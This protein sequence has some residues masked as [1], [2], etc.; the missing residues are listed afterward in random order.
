MKRKS[1]YKIFNIIFIFLLCTGVLG[2]FREQRNTELIA[3]MEN[4]KI[5]DF[6]VVNFSSRD[7]FQQFEQ[8]FSDRI[9]GR[10]DLIRFWSSLN[11]KVFNVLISHDII[12]GKNGFFF[13]P[14][15][16]EHEIVDKGEKFTQLEKINSLCKENNARFIFFIAPHSEWIL[17][18]HLPDKY[19]PVNMEEV[20]GE[21]RQAL[22]ESNI[23]Y[24]LIGSKIQKLDLATRNSMYYRG[25]Y[26]WN[27]KGAHFAS[28]EL[29]N[30]LQLSDKMNLPV[31]YK[32]GNSTADIYTK[33]IGWEPIRSEYEIPWSDKFTE[34]IREECYINGQ[35][36]R[37]FMNGHRGECV[38]YNPE[39]KH[40]KRMLIL[41]D[42]FF[43]AMSRY[44]IQDVETIIYAHN[45]DVSK[46]KENI[47]INWLIKE[48]NPDIVVY[49]KMGA[50]F[51]SYNYEGIFKYWKKLEQGM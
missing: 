12:Q 7:F 31:Y 23:E 15:N 42:S 51:Y 6:P 19:T 20:E 1:F 18:E 28:K 41:G 48:Y 14:F 9:L 44:L 36:N 47:D 17:G 34:N 4:R 43:T 24:C 22:D 27:E 29:L 10:K 32:K 49:E 26:H 21:L 33:K 35:L 5:T 37:E 30:E 13:S 46:P 25:D 11:G 3:E 40:K 38:Y 45:M 2:L 8:W 50:F 39:A 16:L